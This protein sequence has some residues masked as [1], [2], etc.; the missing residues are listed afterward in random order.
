MDCS[1]SL[2]QEAEAVLVNNVAGTDLYGVA[3]V[4]TDPLD[5]VG[6]PAGVTLGRVDDQNVNTGF[7]QS[8]NTLCVV[9][10]IDTGAD[11]V[12]LFLIQ[13][14]QWIFLVGGVVLTEHKV[15]QIVVLVHDGQA[16][17]L[18]IP[19]DVVSFLQGGA[20]GSGNP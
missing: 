4:L 16:V 1:A 7:Q 2:C 14:F 15:H 12:T 10:G 11:Q 13:Q 6:L 19:N 8:G 20:L 5:G 3:V 18:V 17:Q 9:T